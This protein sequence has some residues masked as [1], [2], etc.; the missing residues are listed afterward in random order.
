LH[1]ANK[2]DQL[3]YDLKIGFGRLQPVF[4]LFFSNKSGLLRAF[5]IFDINQ[6]LTLM[7]QR[8]ILVISYNACLPL[9]KS[10]VPEEFVK[11]HGHPLSCNINT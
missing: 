7:E 2:N 10:S 1:T 3:N 6:L 8:P 11:Y 9:F 5:F 4:L